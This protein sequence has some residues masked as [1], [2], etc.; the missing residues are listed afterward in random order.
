[1]LGDFNSPYFTSTISYLNHC[2][3]FINCCNYNQGK[4]KIYPTFPTKWPIAQL[5]HIFMH[6]NSKLN[7]KIDNEYTHCYTTALE[8]I[9]S[10]HHPICAQFAIT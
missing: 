10:D 5:D 4:Q 6:T 3:T 9:A 2:G 8:Q 7:I 1:M